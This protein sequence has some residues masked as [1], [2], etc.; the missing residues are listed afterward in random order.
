MIREPRQ[1]AWVIDV[2]FRGTYTK[3]LFFHLAVV[4]FN[5]PS[6]VFFGFHCRLIAWPENLHP[7]K[8]DTSWS[9]YAI[10]YLTLISSKMKILSRHSVSCLQFVYLVYQG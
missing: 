4:F 10:D 2:I 1:A 5:V 6:F 8:S 3:Y 9:T 7:L